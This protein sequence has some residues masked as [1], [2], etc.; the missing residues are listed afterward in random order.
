MRSLLYKLYRLLESRIAPGL[1]YSQTTYGDVLN[2]R[3]PEHA[4]WLEL[5]CGH[6]LLPEWD[7]EKERRIV[8]RADFVVG[9]DPDHEAIRKHTS[10]A[11]RLAGWGD[12][13]PFADCSFD[14][15]TMN[16]VV[17][18]LEHPATVFG[19]VR[20]VLKP[21]GVVVFHTPNR[22]GYATQVAAMLPESAKAPLARLLHGRAA[23][24]VY[25]TFYRCNTVRDIRTVASDAA[26]EVVSI[27]FIRSSALTAMVPPFAVAELVWLRA[28]ESPGRAELRPNVIG[29]MTRTASTS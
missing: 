29:T 9:L 7:L 11:H 28:L 1:A 8:N 13:L 26:L 3:V 23:D 25:P 20:R 17:E 2:A 22:E 16:M 5:G 14:I 15:V 19:E 6:Q 18:H 27:D 12:Q 24:D 4:R 21:G 10:I